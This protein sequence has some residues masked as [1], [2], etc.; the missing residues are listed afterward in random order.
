ML[1]TRDPPQEKRYIQKESEGI[2]K[3]L[4]TTG[5]FFKKAG[6]SNSYTRQNRF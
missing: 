1:S 5:I 4:H 2:E 6:G 3:I